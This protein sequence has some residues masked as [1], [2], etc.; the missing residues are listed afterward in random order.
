M[1]AA[2]RLRRHPKVA[3]S[4]VRL[5]PSSW[6][7]F[8]LLF[9]VWDSPCTAFGLT[10]GAR[11]FPYPL[12]PLHRTSACFLDEKI[13]ATMRDSAASGGHAGWV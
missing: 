2:E 12:A 6:P 7:A 1:G 5:H 4:V 11:C 3:T 10:F 9:M 8:D 13:G